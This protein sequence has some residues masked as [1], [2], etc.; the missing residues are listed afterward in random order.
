[1]SQAQGRAFKEPDEES[2][3]IVEFNE[4]GSVDM[5]LQELREQVAAIQEKIED[6]A[7]DGEPETIELVP[8]EIDYEA[9]G[10]RFQGKLLTTIEAIE[11]AAS[12]EQVQHLKGKELFNA[13]AAHPEI[14]P[15]EAHNY[16]HGKEH[17]I[18][19]KTAAHRKWDES[20]LLIA[21]QR[22]GEEEITDPEELAE[23]ENS[24]NV[25][26]YEQR[27][28]GGAIKFATP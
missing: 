28:F 14:T 5:Q 4:K 20:G 17:D 11:G 23:I 22:A 9:F 16:F 19:D 21:W 2:D 3:N 18:D 12:H 26:A 15:L 1:M 10:H 8:I 25:N 7:S 6:I 24:H 27:L 13:L